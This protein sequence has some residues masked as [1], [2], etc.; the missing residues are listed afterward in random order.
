MKKALLVLLLAHPLWCETIHE[1]FRDKG[2][3]A[4][5]E[6]TATLP[7][8]A[9]P[10][11]KK[12]TMDHIQSLK[13]EYHQRDYD[14]PADWYLNVRCSREFANQDVVSYLLLFEDYQGGA[15]G[16]HQQVAVMLSPKTKKQIQ[17]AQCFKPGSPWLAALA[18]SSRKQLEQREF[19]TGE[20]I[21]QG[22][23]PTTENYDNVLAGPKGLTVYFQEY[24][25]GP[26]VAGP[27]QVLVPYEAL[28]PYLNP[29][30]PL[31]AFAGP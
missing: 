24:Q 31:A 27:Q 5:C 6:I 13:K 16:G 26:Y 2:K 14:G 18:D 17:L 3:K 12:I 29:R 20:T 8:G 9:N 25:V 21:A 23:A 4:A 10:I 30:G 15:H 1:K 19:L 11:L 7:D 28:R 22:A